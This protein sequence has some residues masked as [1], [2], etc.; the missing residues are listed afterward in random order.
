MYIGEH[1]EQQT[2]CAGGRLRVGRVRQLPINA[3]F[4]ESIAV[5]RRDVIRDAVNRFTADEL[6]EQIERQMIKSSMQV[7]HGD[8]RRLRGL[9][10][11]P[12]H[13]HQVVRADYHCELHSASRMVQPLADR[14]VGHL[15]VG[16]MMC[17]RKTVQREE[18]DR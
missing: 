2:G 8:G 1:T 16:S 12:I 15:G 13:I 10:W 17:P 5:R 7:G 18:Q 3:I 4:T 14:I 6:L 11:T 9:N